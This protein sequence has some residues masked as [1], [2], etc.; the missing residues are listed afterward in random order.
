MR[1]GTIEVRL[2]KITNVKTV[3]KCVDGG[4]GTHR[5]RLKSKLIFGDRFTLKKKGG[6]NSRCC[7]LGGFIVTHVRLL[8][9]FTLFSGESAHK[10]KINPRGCPVAQPL[11][12]LALPCLAALECS[13]CLR[14]QTV[15]ANT[16]DV[17]QASLAFQSKMDAYAVAE[18]NSFDISGS[19]NVSSCTPR[20]LECSRHRQH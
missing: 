8:Q 13:G 3:L 2:H 6:R 1:R 7:V 12:A 11:T 15:F 14:Q 5:D 4:R 9:I 10:I 18:S 17:F 19:R 16:G 20:I